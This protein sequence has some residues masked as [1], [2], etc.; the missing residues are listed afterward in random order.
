MNK[1]QLSKYLSLVLRHQPELIGIT[2]DQYGWVDLDELILKSNKIGKKITLPFIR[3]IVENSDKKRF[4][5]NND[6]TKIKANYGHSIPVKMESLPEIP[7]EF[8]YHGT[9]KINFPSIQ[10]KGLTSRKRQFVHLSR[11]R[12]TA[13]EVGNRHG[14]PEILVIEAKK[15]HQKGYRFFRTPA[16]IWLT[17]WVPPEMIRFDEENR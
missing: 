12:Q 17:E 10:E 16:S 5:L 6:E 11:D 15:M 1:K 13:Y 14:K 2:P 4:S 3:E 7:P 9:I 8:L